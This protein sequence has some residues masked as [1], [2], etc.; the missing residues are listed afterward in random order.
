MKHT[1]TLI[2]LK[3]VLFTASNAGHGHSHRPSRSHAIIRDMVIEEKLAWYINSTRLIQGSSLSIQGINRHLEHKQPLKLPFNSTNK[4][5]Y[6]AYIHTSIYICIIYIYIHMLPPH[7]SVDF[8]LTLRGRL[9]IF[10][11]I[12]SCKILSA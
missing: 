5:G 8:R 6:L 10:S 2:N 12:I 4:C 11:P 3:P 1:F 7:R 9:K